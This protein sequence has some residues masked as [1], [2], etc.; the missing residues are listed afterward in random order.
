MSD[1]RVPSAVLR[2][3]F[4]EQYLLPL[5]RGFFDE[6]PRC[7]SVLVTVGQYWCDEAADAVHCYQVACTTREPTWPEAGQARAD[8]LAEPED[9]RLTLKEAEQEGSPAGLSELQ[10]PLWERAA[11]R[12]FGD[13]FSSA[14]ALDENTD[15]IVAFAS[16]CR[17]VSDQE[18]PSWR[19][20]T[21]YALIVRPE[22]GQAPRLEIMGTMHRPQW[23]DRWDVLEHDGIISEADAPASPS[24]SAASPSPSAA[25]PSPSAASPSPSAASPSPSAASPSPSAASPAP[26]P[27]APPGFKMPALS[28]LLVAVGAV[29]IVRACLGK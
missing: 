28:W 12:A 16:Y 13:P 26:G 1:E 20:H 7:Q 23:E 10:Y 5:A 21:P 19:S 27:S 22:P 18:Q 15:M 6:E 2:E 4:H 11:T 17:E 14:G 9:L 24:P 8:S 29:L 3:R 25:S